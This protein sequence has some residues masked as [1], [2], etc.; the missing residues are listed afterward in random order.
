MLALKAF[1]RRFLR[2]ARTPAERV[3]LQRFTTKDILVQAFGDARPWPDFGPHLSRM[4]RLGYPNLRIRVLIACLYVQSLAL[5]PQ[6][7]REAF[8]LLDDAER[9]VKRMPKANSSRQQ[10]LNGI[11][12]ARRVAEEQGIWP[13]QSTVPD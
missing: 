6:R 2:E 1:E 7:T 8:R 4:M 10:L 9:R 3:H 12:D 11:V 5:F 13:P